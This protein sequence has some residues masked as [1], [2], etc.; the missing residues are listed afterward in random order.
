MDLQIK[1]VLGVVLIIA[2]VI[3]GYSAFSLSRS[4]AKAVSPTASRSFSVS[5]EGKAFAV[6]DIAEFSFSVIT[7]GGNDLDK[8]QTDNN[9]K[10]AQAIEFV[11]TS[12]VKEADIKTSNYNVNP[13]YEYFNCA[14]GYTCPPAKIVGYEINQTVTVKARD[15]DKVG[16]ILSGVVTK[17]ANSVSGLNFTIDNPEQVKNEA[18]TKAI[19]QAKRQAKEVA[20]AGGFRLGKLISIDEFG[21]YPVMMESMSY[22]RGG[23]VDAAVKAV[24]APIEAGSNE[25]VVNVT[26][27]YAI[28]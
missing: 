27:R 26:L 4:Y 28:K 8:L 15:F 13:R 20:K 16:T 25:V 21:N 22:G 14:S 5:G 19:E 11:K 2:L 10:V 24:P 18:R 3:G 9:K 6:P 12:G 7:Q 17:G 1:N 23:A